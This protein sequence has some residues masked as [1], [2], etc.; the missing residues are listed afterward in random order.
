MKS[1]EKIISVGM[2]EGQLS[3]IYSRIKTRTC[4]H[5]EHIKL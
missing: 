3:Q 4:F 5:R 1:H 2:T